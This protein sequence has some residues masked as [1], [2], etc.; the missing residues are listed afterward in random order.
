MKK[1]TESIMWNMSE[2]GEKIDDECFFPVLRTD[3][4]I[5]ALFQPV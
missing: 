5:R 3:A 4:K 2:T 1:F